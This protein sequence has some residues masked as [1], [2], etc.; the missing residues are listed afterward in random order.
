MSSE[1]ARSAN[2]PEVFFQPLLGL[3]SEGLRQA[4]SQ[5]QF[6]LGSL[7]T[8]WDPQT[9]RQRWLE[10]LMESLDQ[11]LRSPVFLEGMRRH[12]ETLVQWQASSEDWA[13]DFARSTG[14]PRITDISGLFERMRIGQDALLAQLR[15]IEGR[16]EALEQRLNSPT[17]EPVNV[18]NGAEIQARS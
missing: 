11:F 15:D 9:L 5:T 4:A 14:W 12:F 6:L 3:W 7:G 13:R 2:G 1:Q 18:S 8:N 10:T 16:L 17:R